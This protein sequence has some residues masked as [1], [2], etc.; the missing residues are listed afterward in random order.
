MLTHG[1]CVFIYSR[2][3]WRNAACDPTTLAQ[4]PPNEIRNAAKTVA[5]IDNLPPNVK[6][7]I[8]FA[9]WFLIVG[10]V[11]GRVVSCG[12]EGVTCGSA[13]DWDLKVRARAH[14]TARHARHAI[15]RQHAPCALSRAARAFAD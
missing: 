6:A 2:A 4:T 12:A 14:P 9:T 1:V 5:W 7:G 13:A 11:G 15:C 8:P 10:T 3:M